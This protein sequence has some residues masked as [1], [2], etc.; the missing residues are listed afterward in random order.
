V[1][2]T[3]RTTRPNEAATEATDDTQA[4]EGQE[5]VSQRCTTTAVSA[6]EV[7]SKSE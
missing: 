5:A 6:N 4:S 3:R 1:P 7:T 2:P